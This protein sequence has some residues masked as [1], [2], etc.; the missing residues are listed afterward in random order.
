MLIFSNII[1]QKENSISTSNHNIQIKT[2]RCSRDIN[3]NNI[4]TRNDRI[5]FKRP[6]HKWILKVLFLYD[7]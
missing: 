2:N 6:M 7:C 3:K 1:I 5:T 4:Y